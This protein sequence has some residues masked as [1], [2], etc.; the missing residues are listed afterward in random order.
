[1]DTGFSTDGVLTMALDASGPRYERPEQVG[2]FFQL[3]VERVEALPGVTRASAINRLPLE[4]GSNSTAT[5]EGRDPNLG[6]GPDIENRVVTSN[7]FDAMGIRLV[8]GRSF[9]AADGGPNSLPAAV[10]NETMARVFWPTGDAIGQRFCFEEG[11][12]L[13]VVGVVADTR[14]WGIER[15]AR[16]EAYELN[17]STVSGIRP[18]FIVVRAG[19]DPAGLVPAIRREVARIDPGVSVADVRTM[20]D[21]VDGATAE[22]RF[23]TLLVGLFAVTALLLVAAAVYALMSFFVARRTAE[24]GVRMALGAT[25]SAVLRLVLANLL[26]LAAAGGGLGLAGAALSAK[27]ARVIV[28]GFSPTD[29]LMLAAGAASLLAVA[30]AGALAPAVRATTIDPVRALRSE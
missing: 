14:Q 21:V 11:R 22:R 12:W 23:A 29:P 25:P 13:T 19:A 9:V 2:S 28:Y 8:A 16:P 20:G 1:M 5:V 3:A 26:A 7:Y 27:A 10:V 30:A 4:G 24:I 15:P 17:Q 18:R 6:T